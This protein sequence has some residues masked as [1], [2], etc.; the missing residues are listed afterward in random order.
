MSITYKKKYID[1]NRDNELL[2]IKMTRDSQLNRRW[3]VSIECNLSNFHTTKCHLF[4]IHEL[5]TSLLSININV[6]INCL[7]FTWMIIILFIHMIQSTFDDTLLCHLW[8]NET[9]ALHRLQI[10]LDI[11]SLDEGN[12]E[13]KLT[14]RKKIFVH[15]RA[16]RFDWKKWII[17]RKRNY[18]D[19]PLYKLEWETTVTDVITR[20][21]CLCSCVR[22]ICAWVRG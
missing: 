2:N 19:A 6:L 7:R 20:Y 22:L 8:M 11:F 18:L 13:K 9:F 21:E 10:N 12:D 4:H 17:H 14:K 5:R 15:L 3:M 1:S 16:N